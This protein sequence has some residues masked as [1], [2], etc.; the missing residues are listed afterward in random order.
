MLYGY[1]IPGFGIEPVVTQFGPV[2][3]WYYGLAYT[4]GLLAVS[5]WVHLKRERLGFDRRDV[6]EFS[7]FFAGGVL[8]GGRIFDVALYE[9]GYFREHPWRILQIWEGGM[10]THGVMLGAAIGTLA[11][12]RLRGKSFLAL[13]DEVVI[14]GAVM[15]ALGRIGNHI[16]G[17]VFASGQRPVWRGLWSFP[18]R[19]AAGIL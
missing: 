3:L 8:L 6:A 13:A 10:A 4:I 7:L 16:N 19:P 1:A 14:P 11:F 17:E 15:M 2:R 18:T 5:F 12:C 9:W